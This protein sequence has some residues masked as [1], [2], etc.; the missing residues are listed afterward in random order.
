MK[1]LRLSTIEWI[2]IRIIECECTLNEIKNNSPEQVMS[3]R[4]YGIEQELNALNRILK[5]ETNTPCK[6]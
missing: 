3:K 5:I 6:H 1:K 2:T 4:Y